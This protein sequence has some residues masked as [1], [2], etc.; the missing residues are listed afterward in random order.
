MP[1][2]TLQDWAIL[3]ARIYA[4]NP[5][6]FLGQMD[7]ES[8]GSW[9]P[10]IPGTSGEVGIPQFMPGTWS[11]VITQHPEIAREFGVN[12][13]PAHRAN[14]PASLFAAAA[15]MRDLLNMFQG[16]YR[17]ALA[18]YNGGPGGYALAQTQHY[19]ALVL[20][21]AQK[22]GNV[23]VGLSGRTGA[24]GTQP[25][26]VDAILKEAMAAV[27]AGG[28]KRKG[29]LQKIGTRYGAL[30]QPETPTATAATI[31]QPALGAP[32]Q[33]PPSTEEVMA[34]VREA[35]GAPSASRIGTLNIGEQQRIQQADQVMTKLREQGLIHAGIGGLVG[36]VIGGVEHA[37][38]SAAHAVGEHVVAPVA[39]AV[40]PYVEPIVEATR[41]IWE[42]AGKYLTWEQQHIG[43][44][45]ASAAV[46][47]FRPILPSGVEHGAEM[48]LSTLLVPSTLV[49]FPG[50]RA[51]TSASILSRASLKALM[52][53]E[54]L[55][56]TMGLAR[57]E[58]G[59]LFASQA[60]TTAFIGAAQRIARLDPETGA[61][62]AAI[63]TLE[64][65][66]KS[67][68]DEIAA[69]AGRE[70]P[71][72]PQLQA[73]LAETELKQREAKTLLAS[74]SRERLA[75]HI[76]APTAAFSA[77]AQEIE[78]AQKV[79]A[80]FNP[81]KVL[82]FRSTVH[83]DQA[84]LEKALRTIVGDVLGP[85]PDFVKL[86]DANAWR[87]T[88]AWVRHLGI[89]GPFDPMAEPEGF[90][91]FFAKKWSPLRAIGI[92]TNLNI[93]QP[94]AG[95]VQQVTMEPTAAVT[96]L[97][98]GQRLAN[99]IAQS[100][101]QMQAAMELRLASAFGQ[102]SLKGGKPLAEKYAGKSAKELAEEWTTTLEK[103]AV[104]Q[105]RPLAPDTLKEIRA[106]LETEYTG[107]LGTVAHA[108]RNPQDYKLSESESQAF[109]FVSDLLGADA[110]EAK[111]VGASVSL[112]Q[113]AFYLPQ[114]RV[115]GESAQ[116]GRFT[117][118][119]YA[120]QFQK[121]T[122]PDFNEF[123]ARA[124]ADGHKTQTDV[125]SLLNWRLGLSA[126]KKGEQMMLQLIEADPELAGIVGRPLK[127]R[128]GEK[129]AAAAGEELA[130]SDEE[131]A[132]HIVNALDVDPASAEEIARALKKAMPGTGNAKLAEFFT[133]TERRMLP[134]GQVPEAQRAS[135]KLLDDA[136]AGRLAGNPDGRD[137]IDIM[138]NFFLN[139]DLSPYGFVQ[140]ARIFAQDPVT[141]L[142][143]IGSAAAWG[144]TEQG[145]HV[146]T[147]QNSSAL[148]FWVGN[149]LQ[150]GHPLDIAQAKGAI[151]A[152]W[153]LSSAKEGNF[154]PG[155]AFLNRE[156]SDMVG[157]AKLHLANTTYATL[158][159]AHGDVELKGLLKG[160]PLFDKIFGSGDTENVNSLARAVT[161]GL[162]N[163]IGPLEIS[164][165][166]T[167]GRFGPIE[168]LMILTPSWLRGNIGLVL[169]A[170]K[171]GKKGVVA[172]H[173]LM[174]QLVLQAFMASKISL[175]AT[176]R[177]PSFD[178][179]SKDFLAAQL[180][181][182]RVHLMPAMPVLRM[183]PRLLAGV[184]ANEQNPDVGRAGQAAHD[185]TRFFEGRLGQAPRVLVDVAR[186]KDF[187]GRKVHPS[188]SYFVSQALPIA[189]GEFME[190]VSEGGISGGEV[191]QRVALTAMGASNIPKTPMR[192]YRE[193]VE[194]ITG[195][196]FAVD[197]ERNFT[198]QEL[199]DLEAKHPELQAL[200]VRS[201]KYK[202]QRP[203]PVS[204]YFRQERQVRDSSQT[205]MKT[206]LDGVASRNEA[207][208]IFLLTQFGELS[209]KELQGRGEFQSNVADFLDISNK[210]IA[211]E[212]PNKF[213]QVAFAY[214][215]LDPEDFIGLDG[216]HH[217]VTDAFSATDGDGNL[218]P[219]DVENALDEAWTMWQGKR[220]SLLTTAAQRDYV[221]NEFPRGRWDDPKAQRLEQRRVK[222]QQAV[223]QYF[224]TPRYRWPDGTPFTHEQE[225]ALQAIRD[226]RDTVL[227]QLSR[228]RYAAFTAGLIPDPSLPSGTSAAILRAMLAAE[229]D[230]LKHG[231]ISWETLWGRQQLQDFLRNPARDAVLVN[232]PDAIRFFHDRIWRAPLQPPRRLLL[233]PLSQDEQIAALISGAPVQ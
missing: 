44:P 219:D 212:K 204:E 9:N 92:E 127:L 178:P 145:R 55:A 52:K 162:N 135:A 173:L 153:E 19:A 48:I 142:R 39:H 49:P 167:K 114:R 124:V 170:E 164:K 154:I 195:K 46:Y 35:V 159:A 1:E 41:P 68:S 81:M 122:I 66:R 161:D 157:A 229:T 218:S 200:Q 42:P 88:N 207:S 214:W 69:L 147:L 123:V 221:L 89:E 198:R 32:V 115:M 82:F 213:D 77:M 102:D 13:D 15:H 47:P 37:A 232:N 182:G 150:M 126:R 111:A 225:R 110:E 73:K 8:A 205:I 61:A 188:V 25:L 202:Q 230:P 78:T 190:T 144:M 131:L 18:A 7:L 210:Q 83:G 223:A 21:R 222:A 50:M 90:L 86:E 71:H 118:L 192:R 140:G 209:A 14:G 117:S 4:I 128:A 183:L 132:F 54:E 160:L 196:P 53:P 168:R 17:N 158:L 215:G 12:A 143:Q 233:T 91:N 171:F 181:W 62:H 125:T 59:L 22:F 174:N 38:G 151:T 97:I 31:L 189:A 36:D 199:R 98:T 203:D 228:E 224:D 85:L 60:R 179:R 70:A 74:A 180:P 84:T 11:G 76:R 108:M 193:L 101:R 34:R 220:D 112:L 184:P 87:Q 57:R 146:W 175:A 24:P 93:L 100:S 51:L 80:R 72:L 137:M 3:A 208:D 95:A 27:E 139:M 10:T 6:V 104:D 120:K 206:Y 129:V 67:L 29:E 152:M 58:L 65:T 96:K 119:G 136:M 113:D 148:R 166:N 103:E 94:V 130:A 227:G 133:G 216:L 5:V 187:L 231:L 63:A 138:R 201:D 211:K 163:Y 105:G 30:G 226:Q 106:K 186:G 165:I 40:A 26:D 79:V 155:M 64:V 2:Q 156:M 176:G 177:M 75:A 45:L 109:R 169:N 99:A 107:V 194:M 43:K 121:R 149:G 197:G 56:A 116:A 134:A 172:R 23:D 28:Q 20:D 185:L 217:S 33:Q 191:G 141:Y 16:D